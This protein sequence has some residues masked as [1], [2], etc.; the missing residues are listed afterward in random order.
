MNEDASLTDG[1]SGDI[2]GH[3]RYLLFDFMQHF[4]IFKCFCGLVP[5]R[6]DWRGPSLFTSQTLSIKDKLSL[7]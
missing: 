4:R 1:I 7:L 5:D 2:S 6:N 3:V